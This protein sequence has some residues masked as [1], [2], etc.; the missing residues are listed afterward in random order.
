[1]YWVP[2]VLCRRHGS[3][4]GVCICKNHGN[5]G[6]EEMKGRGK[7]SLSNISGKSMS[8]SRVH[9][10]SRA[11]RNKRSHMFSFSS[12]VHSFR[13]LKKCTRKQEKSR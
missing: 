8:A 5:E 4:I 13:F 11:L 6:K 2:T 1:M 3:T 10:G 12:E 7:L 9:V